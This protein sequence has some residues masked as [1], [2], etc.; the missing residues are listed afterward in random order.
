MFFII[1]FLQM[2]LELLDPKGLSDPTSSLTQ[3]AHKPNGL[4]TPNSTVPIGPYRLVD[5]QAH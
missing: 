3:Q 2:A 5:Q 4:I 1:F